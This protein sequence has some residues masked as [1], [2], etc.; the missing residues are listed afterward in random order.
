MITKDGSM[1]KIVLTGGGSAGHVLPN[2]A[3]IHELQKDGVDLYY[4]GTN[5]IEKNLLSQTKIP[6]YTFSAR[7]FVLYILASNRFYPSS[8]DGISTHRA[9]C[10]SMKSTSIESPN[11]GEC[12]PPLNFHCFIVPY[13]P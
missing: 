6:F 7:T 3:L 10:F 12:H 5:G 9:D 13:F 11:S 1:K 4:F 8:L 2:V